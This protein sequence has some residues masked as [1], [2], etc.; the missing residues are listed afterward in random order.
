[1]V[2][3]NN[4]SFSTWGL[5]P[6]SFESGLS[7]KGIFDMPRRIGDTE[8]SW[9]DS[10]EA[11]LDQEDIILDGRKISV[12]LL[13]ISHGDD[14]AIATFSNWLIGL[15]SI[16]LNTDFGNFNVVFKVSVQSYG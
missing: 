2:T 1:M 10:V 14:S 5:R 12:R 13:F 4:T 11:F 8:R 15:S 6:I 16:T 3:I 7:V 9:G